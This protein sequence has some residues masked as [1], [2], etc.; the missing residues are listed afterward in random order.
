[1]GQN[2]V[3]LTWHGHSCFTLDNGKWI[4]AVDPY[5]PEMLGFP[6]LQLK[7]HAMLASHQ[8]GDHNY[9]GAVEFLPADKDAVLRHVATDLPWPADEQEQN[10]FYKTIA[11]KHDDSGGKKRG[12]NTVHVIYTNGIS[13]AHLGDLGHEPDTGIIAAMGM[14]DLLLIPVGGHYTIDAKQAIQTIKKIKPRNVV[15]M[16]YQIGYG[17]LPIATVDQ[18]LERISTYFTVHDLGG[19]VLHYDGTGNNYCYLFQYDKSVS[20]GLVP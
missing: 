8:H 6:P 13:V 14:I 5:N 10:F 11:S 17:A 15:P 18:F 12:D 20:A 1:M 3:K 4:L 9:S 16:H 7:A 2:M 19:P